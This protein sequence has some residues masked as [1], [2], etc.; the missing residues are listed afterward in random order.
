MNLP[1]EIRELGEN[2]IINIITEGPKGPTNIHT[3]TNLIINDILDLE[4]NP[5]KIMIQGQAKD[6]YVRLGAVRGDCPGITFIYNCPGSQLTIS[7]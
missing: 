7:Q 3:Y 2:H 4:A 1:A 6:V 5:I